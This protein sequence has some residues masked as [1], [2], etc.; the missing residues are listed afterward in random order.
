MSPPKFSRVLV[1]DDDLI[2]AEIVKEWLG[3]AGYIVTTRESALGVSVLLTTPEKPDV[4]L[5][6]L[7]MPGLSG[8]GL[9]RLEVMQK[10]PIIF[11][12]STPQ[13]ELNTIS[14][15]LGVLGGIQKTNNASLFL[16]KFQ[17]LLRDIP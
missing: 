2:V 14:Q 3:R 5:L 8:T 13:E 16:K 12:S 1:V 4:I 11:H 9:A 6:D 10:T 7:K 15:Q 17:A